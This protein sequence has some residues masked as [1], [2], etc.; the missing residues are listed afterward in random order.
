L[1]LN[2]HYSDYPDYWNAYA[3]QPTITYI[4]RYEGVQGL[5]LKHFN[6]LC[7][8][9]YDRTLTNSWETS[10]S[11]PS[12]LSHQMS[13][14]HLRASDHQYRW[15]DN[16][17]FYDF[18]PVNQGGAHVEHIT[19]GRTRSILDLGPLTLNT[20]GRVAWSGWSLSVS[21]AQLL[22]DDVPR[23]NI[24]GVRNYSEDYRAYS[25]GISAP[26]ENLLNNSNWKV[27]GRLKVGLRIGDIEG[28]RSSIT[29]GITIV[30]FS[31]SSRTPIVSFGV[32]IK[33]SPLVDN[34]GI[35]VQ[36]SLLNF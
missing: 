21:A 13:A 24:D 11:T 5:V 33:A 4:T 15:W 27:S 6:R 1:N 31:G 12:Q 29:C 17:N 8:R 32:N 34:Y 20:A 23:R 9:F 2:F 36:M 26:D 35:Q 3:N 16:K 7:M 25:I 30:G 18:Y 22:P 14:Y 19:I 10:Y 28:N